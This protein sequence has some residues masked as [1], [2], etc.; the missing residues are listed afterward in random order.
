[1]GWPVLQ[2]ARP[3]SVVASAS[4]TPTTPTSNQLPLSPSLP[5]R[6]ISPVGALRTLD[7][8]SGRLKGVFTPPISAVDGRCGT[9]VAVPAGANR[10]REKLTDSYPLIGGSTNSGNDKQV[11]IFVLGVF[12]FGIL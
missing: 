6:G 4:V 8:P 3:V 2:A 11:A 1:M 12:G 10:A 9:T 5:F 7:H